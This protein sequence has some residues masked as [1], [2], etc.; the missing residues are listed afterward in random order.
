MGWSPDLSLPLQWS[1][2]ARAAGLCD[3][4]PGHG[5]QCLL[6]GIVVSKTTAARPS[7]RL[8]LSLWCAIRIRRRPTVLPGH[9]VM[10]DSCGHSSRR[11]D[12]G[13]RMVPDYARGSNSG[14]RASRLCRLCRGR[15]SGSSRICRSTPNSTAGRSASPTHHA[16]QRQDVGSLGVAAPQT[17]RRRP[18]P[19]PRTP[20][21]Y[22]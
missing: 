10:L 3:L 13:R 15:A 11:A 7:S 2:A 12:R 16:H 8:A 17:A 20:D 4:A 1:P 19:P 18:T 22:R 6:S 21:Q 9:A 5:R 14:G